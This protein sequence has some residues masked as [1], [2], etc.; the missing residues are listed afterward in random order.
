MRGSSTMRMRHGR[1]LVA[2]HG[3]RGQRLGHLLTTVRAQLV[4]EG[5]NFEYV[6][7]ENF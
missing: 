4:G 1:N 7:I 6:K 2:H 5:S 3:G